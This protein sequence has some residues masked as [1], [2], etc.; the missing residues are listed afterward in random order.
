M[1]IEKKSSKV[2]RRWKKK[3][4]LRIKKL[5]FEAGTKVAI[6]RLIPQEIGD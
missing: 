6:K 2:R 5:D 3:L 1:K 4:K